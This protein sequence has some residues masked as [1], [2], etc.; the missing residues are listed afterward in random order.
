MRTSWRVWAV[1]CLSAALLAAC[2][3]SAGENGVDGAP[4]L[5]GNPGDPGTPGDPGL[6][7]DPGA[8]GDPG[9]PGVSVGDLSGR[10]TEAADGTAVLGATVTLDPPA[11][12]SVMSTSTGAYSFTGLPAGVYEVTAT[13]GDFPPVTNTVSI[14]AGRATALDL[15]FLNWR[16]ESDAC[17]ACHADS[18]PGVVADYRAS[19]MAQE[20]SCQD[21]HGTDLAGGPGHNPLPTPATCAGCHPN[22]YRGH[23]SNRHSIGLQ[24]TYEAGRLDDLPPCTADARALESGGTATCQAC[25]QI[26]RRCDG[27]HLR[28]RFSPQQARSPLACATCHMGPDHPQYE[29]YS[30]S[31]H[32]VVYATEG[33]GAAPTCTTCHMPQRLT[34]PDGTTYTDHDLSYGIAFGPVGGADSHRSFRR[35]GQLPY[36]IVGGLLQ[37]NPAFD[38]AAVVDMNGANG[39]PDSAFA[40]DVDGTIAQVVDDAAV[41]T[42]RRAQMTSVCAPCHTETFAD[43]QLEVAD[44]MHENAE[45]LKYEAE[46]IIRALNF[47]GLLVPTVGS[48]PANPDA[49][50]A[51]ILGGAMLYRNLSRIE[52]DFFKFYKYDFV[53]TWHGAYH[54]NPDYAHWYGWAELNLGFAD[55]ADGAYSLRRDAALESAIESGSSTVWTVP[56]QGVIYSTGSMTEISDLY[57]AGTSVSVDANGSGTPTTYTGITF[58]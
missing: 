30:T 57:P 32:G 49:V 23:Q 20:V 5:P 13:S 45:I 37:A 2:E 33:E 8:P 43:F 51:I 31:R 7:G 3:G 36:A 14:L 26:E 15:T 28:H 12:P 1:L 53:R 34:A 41:L 10:V 46:D 55:I 29:V 9:T 56:Y 18:D 50:G 52:R 11:A 39:T 44:G 24:R 27:C 48:R 42:A 19:A 38:P 47:D 54:M 6:P 40:D 21:C 35:G 4:G 58:H 25:H 16:P 22:Q 17:T